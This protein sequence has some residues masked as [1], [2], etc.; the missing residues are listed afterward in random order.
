M[1]KRIL[2]EMFPSAVV[3]KAFLKSYNYTIIVDGNTHYIKVLNV[4][5]SNIISIN[6]KFVWEIKTGKPNGINFKTHSKTMLD[7]TEFN[8]LNNQIVVFKGKPYKILKYINESE[9]IDISENSEVYGV[10]YYNSIKEIKL[11]NM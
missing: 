8:R 3:S 1:S 6:S 10:K 5:K 4:S 2:Q 9:V 11:I 7:M